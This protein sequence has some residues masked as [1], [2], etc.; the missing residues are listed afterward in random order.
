MKKDI[1]D[2][3]SWIEIASKDLASAKKLATPPNPLLE[4]AVYH[5]QQAAEKAIKALIVLHG[6]VAPKSHDLDILLDKLRNYIDDMNDLS[7]IAEQLSEFATKYRYPTF[8]ELDE[9]KLT[10]ALVDEAISNAEIF[11]LRANRLIDD[12][13]NQQKEKDDQSDIC[14]SCKSAPCICAQVSSPSRPR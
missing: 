14:D 3:L 9:D 1:T 5:C 12:Y 2:V 8:N 6:E 10:Q 13:Q 7:S 4:T 11:L